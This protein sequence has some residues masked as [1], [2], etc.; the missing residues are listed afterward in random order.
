[1]L[2]LIRLFFEESQP[3]LGHACLAL[4]ELDAEALHHASHSLQGLVGNYAAAPAFN[5]VSTLTQCT[6]NGNLLQA[7]KLLAEATDEIERLR[8]ALA[9]FAKVIE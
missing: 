5:A 4:H 9:E 1:M 8:E 6:R 3:M 7:G 2:E